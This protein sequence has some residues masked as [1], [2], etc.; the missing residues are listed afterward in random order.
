[1]YAEGDLSRDALIGVYRKVL[2]S[3][4][5]NYSD[6]EEFLLENAVVDIADLHFDEFFDDVKAI[7][8][9]IGHS[10]FSGSWDNWLSEYNASAYDGKAVYLKNNDGNRRITDTIESTKRWN[11]YKE[12][13]PNDYMEKI[14]AAMEKKLQELRDAPQSDSNPWSEQEWESDEPRTYTRPTGPTPPPHTYNGVKVG[15]NDPCP[16]GSGKKFKKCH[17]AVV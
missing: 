13:E 3:L 15:R 9:K 6:N 4:L 10:A 5:E 8:D 17:G 14:M 2:D 1:M 16:C 11:I 12:P 7:F